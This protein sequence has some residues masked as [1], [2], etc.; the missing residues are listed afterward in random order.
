[1]HISY[2]TVSNIVIHI[3]FLFSFFFLND[4]PPPE[5][6]TLPLHAALPISDPPLRRKGGGGVRARQDRRVLPS[7]HRSGGRPRRSDRE[8]TRLKS[9]HG[10][11]SYAVLCLEKKKKHK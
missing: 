1:M 8:S 6:S 2:Q 5:I 4:P 9:S 10:H 7:L 11:N 3:V